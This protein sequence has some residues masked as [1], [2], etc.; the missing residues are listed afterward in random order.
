M[1]TLEDIA[2]NKGGD[3]KVGAGN[4]NSKSRDDAQALTNAGTFQ[5][6][7]TLVIVKNILWLTRQA[8]VKLKRKEMDIVAA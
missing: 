8:T 2:L 3:G 5:F 6:I 4:W 1:A 7:V